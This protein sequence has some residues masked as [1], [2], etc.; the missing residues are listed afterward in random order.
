[1]STKRL[2]ALILASTFLILIL[3]SGTKIHDYK[4]QK[5]LLDLSPNLRQPN[6]N[7]GSC[8]YASMCTVLVWQHRE[9]LA[10]I[11]RSNYSGA[12][13]ADALIAACQALGIDY[14]FTKTGDS[15]FLEWCDRTNRG[16]VIFYFPD[17]CVTF[18]GYDS[19]NALVID[20]NAPG[21]YIRIPKARFL[22]DWK[23]Y[24]GFALTAVYSPS[25][26]QPRN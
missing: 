23:S 26:P 13:S 5:S 12:A 8:V 18:A 21:N 2:V 15:G 9:D 24:G 4:S 7:G 11:M 1:M 14:A 3:A 20:N 17:H 10:G 22:Q 25:P 19:D 6:Y 16:A